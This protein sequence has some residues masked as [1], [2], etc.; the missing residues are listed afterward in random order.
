[1]NPRLEQNGSFILEKELERLKDRA[2]IKTEFKVVWSPKSDS[3]NEGKVVGDTILYS[4]DV[5]E[6]LQTLRHEFVDL[7]VSSAIQPYLKLVNVLLSEISEDAYKKKE[8]AVET[9]LNC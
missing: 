3:E 2:G 6:A 4:L 5:E 8:E 9:R 1:M 7:I